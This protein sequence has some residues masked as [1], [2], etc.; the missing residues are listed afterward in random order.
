MTLPINARV[1]IDGDSVDDPIC[2]LD[3]NSDI[4][5]DFGAGL[6]LDIDFAD[7]DGAGGYTG[8]WTAGDLIPNSAADYVISRLLPGSTKASLSCT[9]GGTYASNQIIVQRTG[10][11]YPHIIVSQVNDAY[12]NQFYFGLP[13]VILTYILENP[14]HQ[15]RVSIEEYITRLDTWTGNPGN[16]EFILVQTSA[17]T[18]NYLARIEG[19]NSATGGFRP[20]TLVTSGGTRLGSAATPDLGTTYGAHYKSI[21][22]A[23]W[24]GTYSGLTASQLTARWQWGPQASSGLHL[25]RSSIARRLVLE[26]MTVSQAALAAAITAGSA[27]TETQDW[28]GCNGRGAAVWSA[29]CANADYYDSA[30]CMGGISGTTMTL[31]SIS[32]GAVHTGQSVY[33]AG[34]LIGT[35]VSGSGLVWT[36]SASATVSSGTAISITGDT[37]NSPASVLA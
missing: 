3:T 35:I 15:F 36:L 4:S 33:V 25:S 12:A 16:C 34:V 6:L 27:A 26:D 21:G 18:G 11:G 23:S 32:V 10:K 7:P 31:S 20:N 24:S 13:A 9:I 28:A 2:P 5:G 22:V 29:R 17:A 19:N 8:N 1:L 14:T 37:F 30:I